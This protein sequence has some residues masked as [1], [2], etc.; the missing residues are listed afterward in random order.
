M[1]SNIYKYKSKCFSV[2]YNKKAKKMRSKQKNDKII[3][4]EI[5]YKKNLEK[6][7]IRKKGSHREKRRKKRIYS[8]MNFTIYFTVYFTISLPDHHLQYALL[9]NPH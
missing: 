2:Y 1:V 6:E 3:Q 4:N 5:L 7:S 8:K 9:Y